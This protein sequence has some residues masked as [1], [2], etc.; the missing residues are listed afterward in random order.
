MSFFLGIYMPTTVW[1]TTSPNGFSYVNALNKLSQIQQSVL[2]NP[3]IRRQDINDLVDIYNS[4]TTHTHTSW[5]QSSESVTTY[6]RPTSNPIRYLAGTGEYLMEWTT[7]NKLFYLTVTEELKGDLQ[8]SITGGGAGGGGGAGSGAPNRNPAGGGGG[9]G[10]GLSTTVT[11]TADVGDVIEIYVGGAGV[12]GFGTTARAARAGNGS[13]GGTSYVK[14]G[15]VMHSAAGGSGGGGALNGWDTSS[16]SGGTGGAWGG[17]NGEY[18]ERGTQTGFTYTSYGGAGGPSLH[19]SG[20][21]GKGGNGGNC[22]SVNSDR[23]NAYPGSDG[24]GGYVALKSPNYSLMD[25][26]SDTQKNITLD[27]VAAM[28][29]LYNATA[30][31]AHSIMDDIGGTLH[32]DMVGAFDPTAFKN[33]TVPAQ[34]T[35]VSKQLILDI[36]SNLQVIANHSHTFNDDRV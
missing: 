15:S 13:D 4:W 33:L 2:S 23:V 17:L 30:R 19:S 29:S 8:F 1:V 35:I 20:L 10:A 27:P 36:I 25:K 12:G 16:R 7:Q 31:H 28:L 3:T 6:E 21:W 5:D 9:G 18:K 24:V 26:L 34:K 11:I 22:V 14:L 32:S